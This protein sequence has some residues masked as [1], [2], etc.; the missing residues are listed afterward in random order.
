M[1][2][3]TPLMAPVTPFVDGREVDLDHPLPFLFALDLER[4]EL[5]ALEELL[6]LDAARARVGARFA[7]LRPRDGELPF[8]RAE[9]AELPLRRVFVWAMTTY[10]PR[11]YAP[12]Y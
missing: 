5:R 9:P 11:C 4:C 12:L 10:L 8:L 6:E 7:G 1:E 3:P 2:L